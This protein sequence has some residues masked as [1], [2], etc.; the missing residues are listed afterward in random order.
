LD[1][2]PWLDPNEEYEVDPTFDY[3]A[4]KGEFKIVEGEVDKLKRSAKMNID[5]HSYQKL[6]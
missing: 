6:H 5:D 4:A 2:Y 3:E 1:K